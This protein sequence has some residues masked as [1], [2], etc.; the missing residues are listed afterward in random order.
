MFSFCS[1]KF[2]TAP[3]TVTDIVDPSRWRKIRTYDKFCETVAYHSRYISSR[4]HRPQWRLDTASPGIRP[5]DLRFFPFRQTLDII[6]FMFCCPSLYLP[7]VPS[8]LRLLLSSGL[9]CKI[10]SSMLLPLLSPWKIWS[11][12]LVWICF[13]SVCLYYPPPWPSEILLFLTTLVFSAFVFVSSVRFCRFLVI[14]H[15]MVFF[16]FFVCSTILPAKK[17]YFLRWPTL[18]FLSFIL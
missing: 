18:A 11:L 8:F 14:V 9:S 5:D 4:C 16:L 3:R 12:W 17:Y 2:C 1:N 10:P 6:Y 7:R 15:I 13:G